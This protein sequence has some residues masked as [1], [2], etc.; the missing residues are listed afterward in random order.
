MTVPP[1]PRRDD[2]TIEQLGRVRADPYHWMKDDN[3][4]AVLRDP[5]LLRPDI[6][7]HLKAENAYTDAMLIPT[8]ALQAQIV[9]EMKGRLSPSESY[10]ALPHGP[11]AYYVR[12]P[13]G[14]QHP[15][16]ARHPKDTPDAEQILLDADAL[17][18]ARKAAGQT[19]FA[20]AGTAHSPDHRL[21]AYALDSQ[22][23][24]LYRVH[25][26][27]L[28]TGCE[29]A[30]VIDN[31]S[32]DFA[33]SPDS[34]HLFWTW[35]DDHG[36]PTRI[37]RRRLGTHD[38]VL[39]YAEPD[40]GFFI[41]VSSARSG[42][43]IVVTSNDHDTS[44][45]WLIPGDQP[46]AEPVCVAPREK[47]VFY[48]LTHWGD[49][50][51]IRTNVDGAVDFKLMEMPD[52]APSRAHWRDLVPHRPGH[53]VTGAI[54][55][56]DHLAWLEWHDANLRIVVRDRG[57][58]THAITAA[59]PAYALSL[60]GAYA[61]D[62]TELRYSYQSPT[63]PR[64]WFA[65]DMRTRTRTVLK[66][67]S[68]PS[69][70]DPARYR[71][72]RLFATAPDGALVPITVLM[73]ADVVPDGSAPLLLYG[74][75]SYGIA[76]EPTFST[77]DLSLVDRGWIYAVAHVRGGS[78][79]GW[80]WFLDGRATHKRNTFTDFIACADHLT[81]HGYGRAGR[82]VAD[83]RSAGG[84]LMGAITNMRPELFAGIVS[85]VPFVDVLNTMSDTSLPLTPP[86]WPEWGNPIEDEAAYDLIAS[87]SPYDNI[88][89]HAYPAVLAIGGLTDPRVTYW[90][91]AKWIAR[92]RDH[93]RSDRPLLLRINMDAGHKGARGRFEALD[94]A[95]LIHAFAIWAIEGADQAS[96]PPP[97]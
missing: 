16:Y 45:A 13:E 91:P 35:R 31:C 44:E 26:I 7:D 64:Q 95:A 75:G 19:Y 81:A 90:E 67:Q 62:T 30:E 23:S 92:L 79:K 76:I 74:Y 46:E 27:D 66:S 96:S 69:G 28:D 50:F 47:G 29:Q 78:E 21:F 52:S 9:A 20:L 8:R 40:P 55:F 73:R 85:V 89:D 71:C 77:R 63:T 93:T 51:V 72:E 57:G 61:F 15:V 39:V 11:W 80:N 5:S 88:A 33:F 41:G 87:Y 83:G 84:M 25:I 37:Y 68:V 49:R 70:H 56:A 34:R 1:R 60:D 6:A 86:E 65:Y 14:A 36:R 3:W 22:G 48:D 42:R 53:Y 18:A 4:Q 32:G 38:D 54:T 58:D 59:D 2:H 17:A 24:E 43:W 97:T 12:Y 10:P 94:E 82:I